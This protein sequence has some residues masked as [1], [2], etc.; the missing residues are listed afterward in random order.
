MTEI[1][2]KSAAV[3]AETERRHGLF[4]R[5]KQ[6]Y[7]ASNKTWAP[8]LQK[9]LANGGLSLPA[10]V[11]QQRREDETYIDALARVLD[12]IEIKT[13]QEESAPWE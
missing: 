4:K 10:Y 3:L 7:L 11:R 6:A 1:R 12:G 5:H 9:L 13:Q 8:A 2:E